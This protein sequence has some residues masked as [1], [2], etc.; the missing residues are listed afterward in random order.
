M[1]PVSTIFLKGLEDGRPIGRFLAHALVAMGRRVPLTIPSK[2][3]AMNQVEVDANN[4]VLLGRLLERLAPGEIVAAVVT[5]RMDG[6]GLGWYP[7]LASQSGE[8]LDLLRQ[9]PDVVHV[10]V[11]HDF[12]KR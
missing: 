9:K 5:A 10:E 6:K 1:P 12:G 8:L 3:E 4:R 7:G 11:D 2:G